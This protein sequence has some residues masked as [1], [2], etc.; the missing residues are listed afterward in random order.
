M[1]KQNLINLVKYHVEKNEDA[2]RSEVIEIAKEFDVSGD[3]DISEYLMDLISTTNYYTPQAIYK[4]FQYL[5]KV[6]YIN[7]PLLLPDS[8]KEDIIK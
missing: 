7:S 4:N 1:K 6:N 3:Q 8:I 2:F 5:R